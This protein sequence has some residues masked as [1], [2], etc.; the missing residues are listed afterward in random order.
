MLKLFQKGNL[1]P[2]NSNLYELS[3]YRM[4]CANMDEEENCEE[5]ELMPFA[6]HKKIVKI[7]RERG[8]YPHPE[9]RYKRMSV[10][11]D[12]NTV[13][14]T[15]RTFNPNV[16][17]LPMYQSGLGV[18]NNSAPRKDKFSNLELLKIQNFLHLAPSNV[19]KQ[20][21]AIKKFCRLVHVESIEATLILLY[22][23]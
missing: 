2:R 18:Y 14:P 7:T 16:V 22:S 11:Q 23:F 6:P 3:T 4:F 9:P 8:N 13:W 10:T 20:C 19:K 1:F 21:R 12:W 17:P 5:F 15:A